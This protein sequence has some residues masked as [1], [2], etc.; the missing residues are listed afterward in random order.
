MNIVIKLYFEINLKLEYISINYKIHQII[1]LLI[2]NFK[3]CFSC[4]N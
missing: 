2:I 4:A 3:D 1:A